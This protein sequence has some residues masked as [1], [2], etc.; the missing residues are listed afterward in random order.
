MSACRSASNSRPPSRA[1]QDL[2]PIDT[3]NDR[4]VIEHQGICYNTLVQWA[5]ESGALKP[6]E[7]VE[8]LEKY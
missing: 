8:G 4:N 5:R 3:Y 2:G 7:V 6:H 1:Y